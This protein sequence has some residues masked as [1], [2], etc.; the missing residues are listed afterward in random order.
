MQTLEELLCDKTI[1]V[2]EDE[3]LIA[4]YLNDLLTDLGCKAVLNAEDVES[5]AAHLQKHTPD[6][7][8]LDLRLKNGRLSY[9]IAEIL[10]ARNTPIVFSTGFASGAL[11]APWA[12]YPCLEKPYSAERL[13]E[14]VVKAFSVS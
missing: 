12:T 6:L 3:V 5:A 2:V 14:A 13:G 11:E 4:S 10:A 8:I 9:P 1:L 7:A